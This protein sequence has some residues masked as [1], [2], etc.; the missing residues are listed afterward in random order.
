MVSY[1]LWAVYTLAVAAPDLNGGGLGR[2]GGKRWQAKNR[3]YA[4]G[5]WKNYQKLDECHYELPH[6][7]PA[8][9]PGATT[10]I[11]KTYKSGKACISRVRFSKL[12]ILIW[13]LYSTFLNKPNMPG[14]TLLLVKTGST[15]CGS[16]STFPGAPHCKNVLNALDI[17]GAFEYPLY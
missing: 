3:I 11:I 16:P 10:M 2:G 6:P 14:S 9:F 15:V 17:E 4:S 12:C 13:G 8:P 5:N 1:S 7:P